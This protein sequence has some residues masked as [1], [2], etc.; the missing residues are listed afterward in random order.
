VAAFILVSSVGAIYLIVAG[1]PK[2]KGEYLYFFNLRNLFYLWITI[3]LTKLIHEFAHAYTAKR[4]GLSVP[5]MGLAFLIFFPCLYCNTTDAWRLANRRERMAI[6]GAG[7]LSEAAVAVFAT[8][9]WHFTKPGVINSLSFYLMGVSLISTL[10]F[11]G[12][13]LLKFDGYFVLSDYLNKPNLYSKSFNQL[14]YIFWNRILG[15]SSVEPSAGEFKDRVLFTTYGVGSF[16]YRIFLYVGIIGGVYY[17]FDKTIGIVLAAL[18]LALFVARPI[19]GGLNS[20][21]KQRKQMRPRL[22]GLLTAIAVT[23]LLMVPLTYPLPNNSVYP[24]YLDSASRQKM[25]VPL[26]TWISEVKVRQGEEVK[27]GQVLYSL[28]SRELDLK[29]SKEMG[30]KVIAEK[31]LEMMLLDDNR[32]AEAPSKILELLQIKA[33][34]RKIKEELIEAKN[35]FVAPFDGIVTTMDPRMQNGFQPGAGEIVG[36]LESNTNCEIHGL[37]PE[38]D[39]H[40]IRLGENARVQF[41]G[42]PMNLYDCVI[43]EIKPFSEENLRES[44]FSSRFGGDLATEVTGRDQKDSPLEA[45]YDCVMYF[46]NKHANI[47]LGMTGRLIISSR[48]VS[49]TGMALKKLRRTF[50]RE[51]LL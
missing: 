41:S 47:P 33:E 9:V 19:L 3:A 24:C 34:E 42:G 30:A 28:D 7:V 17:R 51:S 2:I 29:L 35:G 27:K 23:A 15:V 5:E 16:M 44:P 1:I 6:S 11:N 46:S 22:R 12:N 25:T 43:H 4:F 31:E 38:E 18:A 13:P 26:H 37:I 14:R 50:N 48:P 21:F 20:L 32:R 49:I 8:Y 45:Y 39:L 10:F 36:E 40:K